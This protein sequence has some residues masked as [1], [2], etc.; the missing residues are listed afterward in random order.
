MSEQLQEIKD[1]LKAERA[2]VTNCNGLCDCGKRETIQ[3][4]TDKRVAIEALVIKDLLK[5]MS[6]QFRW[7]SSER[8][9]ADALKKVGARQ[10]CVERYKGSLVAD[11]P[12]TASWV[13]VDFFH[14]PVQE[15]SFAPSECPCGTA[16]TVRLE[17]DRERERELPR[18]RRGRERTLQETR[19]SKPTVAE[20]TTKAEAKEDV[21]GLKVTDWMVIIAVMNVMVTTIIF[22]GTKVWKLTKSLVRGADREGQGD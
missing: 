17:R 15:C 7:V 14:A 6:C 18:R 21:E 20:A 13:E 11:E 16:V 10:S 3:Q 19:G 4:A 8:Q 5:E 12:Y 9:L 1:N 22:A 2:L